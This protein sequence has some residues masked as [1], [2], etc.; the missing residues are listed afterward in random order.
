MLQVLD[1]LSKPVQLNDKEITQPGYME[2]SGEFVKGLGATTS[3]TSQSKFSTGIDTTIPFS[4]GQAT[5]TEIS[6]R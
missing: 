6:P 2:D 3:T 5:C 4:S 1:M